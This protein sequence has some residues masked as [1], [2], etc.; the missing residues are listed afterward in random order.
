MIVILQSVLGYHCVASKLRSQVLILYV[1]IADKT[2]V[3]RTIQ[4]VNK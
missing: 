2:Y 3:L 4:A 1:G